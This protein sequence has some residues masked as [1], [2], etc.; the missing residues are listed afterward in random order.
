MDHLLDYLRR[1]YKLRSD[2]ALAERLEISPPV[3]SKLRTGRTNLT[4][5]IILRIHDAFDIPIAKIKRI[6]YGN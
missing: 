6:A 5:S 2:A 1:E 4:P 3:I